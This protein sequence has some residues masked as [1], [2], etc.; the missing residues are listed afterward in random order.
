[1]STS[2]PP[3]T[4]PKEVAKKEMTN[5]LIWAVLAAAL[6]VFAFVYANKPDV[7]RNFYLIIGAIA[8]IIA[9]VNGYSAW[10][11]YEK[12]KTPPVK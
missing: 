11:S 6:S 10:Q 2:P 12:T 5:A 1:M 9:L 4:D 3:P 7:N 8:A